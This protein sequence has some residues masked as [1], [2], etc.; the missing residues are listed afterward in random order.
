MNSREAKKETGS[1]CMVKSAGNSV[2]RRE[3]WS[4]RIGRVILESPDSSDT[5][6]PLCTSGWHFCF[7]AK[8]YLPI[9]LG[10]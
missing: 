10:K 8:W 2:G 7:L 4:R 5:H 1:R 3:C 6:R 9:A